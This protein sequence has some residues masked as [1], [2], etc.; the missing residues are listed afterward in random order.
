MPFRIQVDTY[1][2][3]ANGKLGRYIHSASCQI[4]VFK[5]KGA[6]RKLKTDKDKMEKRS[7]QDKLK[8]Q[9][10]Y[11]STLLSECMPSPAYSEQL[12]EN[13]QTL[14][15]MEHGSDVVSM[16]PVP[17]DINNLSNMPRKSRS[18]RGSQ[19]DNLPSSMITTFAKPQQH[20]TH[21]VNISSY[22]V[23]TSVD[24]LPL[25]ATS[26]QT[27][28]W[29]ERNRFSNYLNTLNSFTGSDLLA[30]SRDDIIQICG[31]A[32][33]IRL[34]NALRA[35]TIHPRLTLYLT[36]A[37]QSDDSGM[38]IYKAFYLE[39]ASMSELS[40]AVRQCL[41]EEGNVSNQAQIT[42]ILYQPRAS[43][44]Y[45]LVTDEVVSQMKDESSFVISLI[46]HQSM[47]SYQVILKPQN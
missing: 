43:S 8:Y 14:A 3:A 7:A 19:P 23:P 42:R 24:L 10:S 34:Y 33:G 37:P 15:V 38:P 39:H 45:V 28:E 32:D 29:L 40:K 12:G 1:A 16:C 6:D 47:E 18:K 20:A 5:P 17:V 21:P 30:L 41:I 13:Q 2:L 46:K 9:P 27:Q 26:Q 31:P 4:K 11:D 35:K 36:C 25:S 44:I 22:A